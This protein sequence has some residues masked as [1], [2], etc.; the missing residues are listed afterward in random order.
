MFSRGVI[1]T[2]PIWKSRCLS[3]ALGATLWI[4]VALAPPADAQ[5][6]DKGALGSNPVTQVPAVSSQDSKNGAASSSKDSSEPSDSGSSSPS[7]VTA[8]GTASPLGLP[9]GSLR[10]GDFFVRDVSYTEI[11]DHTNYFAKSSATT[12]SGAGFSNVTNLFQ[13]TL[14]FN[15]LSRQNQIA[16]QYQPRLAIING[17]VYPDYSN[18]NASFDMIVNQGPRWSVNFRDTFTY[19]SSQN[20]YATFYTDANTQ[21]GTTIQKNFLDGP[22][23]LLSESATLSFSYRWSPRT[24]LYFAPNFNYTRTTGSQLGTLI[25]RNYGGLVAIGFQLSPRQTIGAFFNS[26]YVVISGFRG[27]TRIYSMGLSYSRQMGP[28]WVVSGSA[29]GTRA[30]GSL[31]TFPWTFTGTAS[32]TRRFQRGSAGVAYSRDLA[33]G[34]VTNHFADRID[35]VTNWQLMRDLQWS[36]SGGYQRES[37]VSNPISAY[38]TVS[39]FD[40]RLAPR[41]NAFVNYGYR[42]QN[43]DAVRVLMGH[44]NFVSAGIRWECSPAGAY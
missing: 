4:M 20:L 8:L 26:Q 19:F 38:Y 35:A 9:S 17:K 14:A 11:Y 42:L 13:T 7:A 23:S 16:A 43:G 28:A 10:W 15:H 31:N 6:E 22:G 24:T 40:F 32:L 37:S 18:Q 41:V 29:A 44:R 33:M 2:R 39:Q 30:P 36:V 12:F 3:L 5:S 21:T 25:S 1:M 27:N 34:Y